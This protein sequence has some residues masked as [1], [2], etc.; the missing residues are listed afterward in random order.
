[1]VRM[2]VVVLSRS[3]FNLGHVGS[4]TRSVGQI[5]EKSYFHSRGHIF[6]PVSMKFGQNVCLDDVWVRL[7]CGSHRIKNKV[8]RTKHRKKLVY[9]PENIFLSQSL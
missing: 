8:M 3:Q 9:T 2:F 6:D 4:K 5:E 7:R 1:M